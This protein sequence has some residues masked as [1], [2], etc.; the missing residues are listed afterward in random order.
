MAKTI[1][2]IWNAVTSLL[3]VLMV[4]LAALFAGGKLVGLDAFIVQ[5]GSM[6]PDYPVG[7]VVYV[8]KV[9][10][11]TLAEGDVITFH[12]TNS[13]RGT[14][15][16]V[17]VLSE[18]GMLAFRT[19]GDANGAPDE[20]PVMAS[21]VVGKVVWCVPNLGFLASYIQHPPGMYVGISIVATL[22]LLIILPELIFDDKRAIKEDL[23]A[24]S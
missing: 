7:A 15:R 18:G 8:Q 14:H 24:Q 16:I 5:S 19:K 17:E 23:N 20:F 2:R 13:T 1:K 10:A 22:L 4:V 21:D 11:S 6:E 12:L 9:D 3:V